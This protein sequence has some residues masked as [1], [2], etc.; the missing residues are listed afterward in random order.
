MSMTSPEAEPVAADERQQ[1]ATQ[2]DTPTADQSHGPLQGLKILDISTVVAAPWSATLLADLGAEVLKAELPGT[3]DPLRALP[4]H[5]EG[6]PLWWKVTN[7]NKQGITLDLRKPE[8]KALFEKL[9]PR[10]DVLVENF[11]PG[12]LANWGLPSE[13]LFALQ[14]KLIVMRMT[15]FGQTGPYRNKPGFARTF[16]AMSGF[17]NMCGEANGPPLHLGFPIADAVAGL[18]GAIGILAALRHRLEHPE[19]PGQEIDCSLFESMFRVLDFM[20]I[21]YDQLGLVRGRSGSFSQYAAP[22]NIYR[23]KEGHWASIAASTQSI[24]VRLCQAIGREDLVSDERFA[25]N[26]TRVVHRDALD[27]IISAEVGARTMS[28]LRELLDGN[29]VG[30]SP[31]YTVEDVFDDPQVEARDAIVSVA[32]EQLGPLRMQGVVPK[33][34]RT[35]GSVVHAGPALGQHNR[36]IYQ[37]LLGLTDAEIER[38]RGLGAI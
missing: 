25:S 28:E 1:Q 15:G 8:G 36:Q 30:F 31:V 27:A 5:K 2:A 14:P 6:V 20:P 24:Y 4:P 12:T 26:Q 3:G 11:R 33:F 34:S 13:R 7:R 9:L 21:E 10:F 17:T 37:D 29:E 38:L 19:A 23:T 16:E 22:G 35:P 18:F 32:D